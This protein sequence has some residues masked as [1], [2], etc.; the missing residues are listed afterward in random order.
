M[1]GN[2]KAKPNIDRFQAL[3]LAH[4]DSV[5]RL[6]LYMAGNE[7]DAQRLVQETYL[8]AYRSFRRFEAETICKAWLLGILNDTLV[9]VANNEVSRD[10]FDDDAIAAI[11]ELPSQ[12]KS[13]ILLADVEGLPYSEIA[14]IVGCPME[15]VMSRLCTGRRLLGKGLQDMRQLSDTRV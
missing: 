4:I 6:A 3:A 9:K 12:Y 14:D 1:L 7:G 13:V 5:Y 8:K 10:Q 2:S 11:N 15:I